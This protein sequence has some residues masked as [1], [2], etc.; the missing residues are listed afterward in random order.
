[1]GASGSIHGGE[2][3]LQLPM[4]TLPRPL[5]LC[6]APQWLVRYKPIGLFLLLSSGYIWVSVSAI[7]YSDVCTSSM[8]SW[9]NGPLGHLALTSGMGHKLS[10]LRSQPWQ[11]IAREIHRRLSSLSASLKIFVGLLAC[12]RAEDG[13]HVKSIWCSYIKPRFSSQ[14]PPITSPVIPVLGGSGAPSGLLRKCT[15]MVHVHTWAGKI[16]IL[17]K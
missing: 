1:M 8:N 13:S 3:W 10:G 4:G 11:E 15:Q 12:L 17:I 7:S 2:T 16:L 5:A 14:H 6:P 9:T